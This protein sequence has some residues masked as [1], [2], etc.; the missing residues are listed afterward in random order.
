MLSLLT[1]CTTLATSTMVRSTPQKSCFH[2]CSHTTMTCSSSQMDGFVPRASRRSLQ[3]CQNWPEW[4]IFPKTPSP[5]QTRLLLLLTLQMVVET[6][7]LSGISRVVSSTKILPSLGNPRNVK[8]MVALSIG[9]ASAPRVLAAHSSFSI[10]LIS[11]SWEGY[12]GLH[13][14]HSN[15]FCF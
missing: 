3:N 15:I 1:T 10:I 12:S 14:Q 4:L 6:T 9:A 13:R 2:M 8:T 11:A 5:R 7:M